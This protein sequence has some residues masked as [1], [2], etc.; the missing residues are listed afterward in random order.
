M[1]NLWS[2]KHSTVQLPIEI[3]LA[4][5]TQ[6][7]DSLLNS[8][9]QASDIQGNMSDSDTSASDLNCSDLMQNSF[10][11]VTNV[12]SCSNG[13]STSKSDNVS[14][15]K[16]SD[17][18]VQAAINAHILD[19]LNRIGKRLDKIEN[20]D[21]KKTLDKTKTK[22]VKN[23]DKK[24]KKMY[25]SMEQRQS[26]PVAHKVWQS[27]V[28]DKALLQLKVDQRLQELTDLAKSGTNSTIKL[29]RGGNFEILVKQ[30][31]KW[32]HEYVLSG[33]NKERVT[34]DQLNVTQWVAGFGRTMRDE[35]DPIM[36]QN[37]LEYLI[38]LMN[39]ANDFSW[40]SAKASHAVL[41]CRMEQGEIK[42]FSDT[43]SIDRVRRANAQKHM[44]IGASANHS[45]ANKIT[46][47]VTRSMPCTYYNQGTC[48]QQKTHETRGGPI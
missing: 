34:Y 43:A 15:V 21:C 5:D 23:K 41:L 28:S 10:D 25:D 4:G 19:Q 38:A 37:M 12:K 7:I 42:Y 24:S 31:V 44:P 35:S 40:T 3:Q 6:F 36:T 26:L 1:Y 27:S 39:D 17:S 46:A 2:S 33:L 30:R 9:P 29:Q 48:M 8:N 47:K 20:K 18:D 14:S 16:D 45:V 22:S 11:S 32:P 13:P